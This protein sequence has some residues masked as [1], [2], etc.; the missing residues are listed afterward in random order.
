[1]PPPAE[2]RGRKTFWAAL[3]ILIAAI[4]FVLGGITVYHF[5]GNEDARE[6][7]SSRVNPSTE[8][9]KV[10]ALGRIE[11]KDDVLSLGVP[12]PDRITRIK[13]KEGQHVKK[14]EELV[15]LD[16]E[17]MREL[18]RKLAV[19][20]RRQAEKRLQAIEASGAAQIR[21]EEIRQEQV[22]QVG[23]LEIE[24]Q[25][26]K[27][28]YLEAQ[29]KNVRRDYDRY[30]AAGD[31]VADQDKDKQKLLLDQ[32]ETELSAARSQH[33]KMLKSRDFNRELAKAQLDSA[34]AELER[35]KSA[36]SL[37]L[38]DKQITQAEER[39]RE[40]QVRAPS[41]GKILRILLHEGE[42]VRGQPILQMANTEQM[43]VLTEVYETDI[44]RVK[45]GQKATITS[46]IFK[47]EN[48]LT[49]KVVWKASSIGKARVV[50]LDPRA[51]VDNRVAE[52]K[53]ALDQSERVADLIGHQVQVEIETES[54]AES[55]K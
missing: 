34:R 52:V 4:A 47:R 7:S 8:P 3:T 16:G 46:H 40:T 43:I 22:E 18:E 19:I 31:T 26:T 29:E 35:G 37:D 41:A 23:P 24:A 5:Y 10:V 55:R 28:K 12:M 36:I 38:L 13:V 2:K 6:A 53:V 50:P 14:D 45:I 54:H 30:L 42:L 11:P 32:V 15:I 44:Q 48:A 17:V 21:V 51:A 25:M 27:I 9:D 39:V 1:M 49:G 20:Q 33:Q